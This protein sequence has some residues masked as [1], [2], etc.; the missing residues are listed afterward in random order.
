MPLELVPAIALTFGLAFAVSYAATPVV[1]RLALRYGF[2]DRPSPRRGEAPKPRLGGVA[3]YL[4]FLI[5]TVVSA[6][7]VTGRTTEE[8]IKLLGFLVGATIVVAM[9][10]I[11]DRRELGPIPQL[12]AQIVGAVV[13]IASGITIDM[14]ANPLGNTWENS[15]FY[16]PPLVAA[17][18]TLFWL[19]GAMNTINFVDGLDGLAGGITTIAAIVLFIHSFQL[20][21]YSIAFL[22]LA[23]AGVALGFL[24][25]NF[26]P[27]RITMGTSGAVFL[28]YAL[29]TLSIIGGTKAATVLLVLGVPI[30]DT[31]WIILRRIISGHSP[32][33]GDRS[34]LHHRLMELG[35][36][37]QQIVLL[38]YLV[39]GVFGASALLLSSR[40]AKLYVLLGMGALLLGILALV[41]QKR[42][43]RRG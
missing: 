35:L 13:A 2:V 42:W 11:D 32:F 36:S 30:L 19:V 37:Q 24:P 22:P 1:R 8:W 23:L 41:A 15:M 9:G 16:F 7:F 40:I 39:C 17:A 20:T 5:A 25:H 26:F 43:D 10:I 18:L 34:H 6:P 3:L 14:I 21:Q 38:F 31:A 4:A 27:A 28:G 33:R 29:G 12:G